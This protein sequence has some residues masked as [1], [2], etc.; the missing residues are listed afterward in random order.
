[1][2]RDPSEVVNPLNQETT[3]PIRVLLLRGH[4]QSGSRQQ[5]WLEER[6]NVNFELIVLPGAADANART[7]LM[8]ADDRERP[9]I[10]WWNDSMAPDF[11]RWRNAGLMVELTSWIDKYTVMRD[12]LNSQD[13]RSLFFAQ[14]DGR[15][16]RIPGDISEPGCETI[17]LRQDWLDTLGLAIP[18]TLAELE[19]VLYAFTHND[20][21]R[22]GQNDTYGWGAAGDD[23]R[24]FWP[25]IQGSGGGYGNHYY[26]FSRLAD[27]S[28]VYSAAHPDTRIWVERVADLYRRGL[29]T[30]NSVVNGVNFT[31]EMNRGYFGGWHRW[32]A[33]NNPTSQTT[34]LSLNPEA[35]LVPVDMVAGD[36]GR[37]QENPGFLAAWCFF[38]ITR[39]ASDPERLFALWDDMQSPGYDGPYVMKR[40]GVQGL[41]WDW[42]PDGTFNRIISATENTEM[43]FGVNIFADMFN[44]KDRWNISNTPETVALFENRGINSREAYARGVERKDVVSYPVWNRHGADLTDIRD[45]WIWSV[46]AGNESINTWDAYITRLNNAGMAEVIEELTERMA[47]QDRDMREFLS[48]RG[49]LHLIQ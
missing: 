40:H 36:N 33:T 27:G 6:Y 37:P 23:L 7:S 19:N 28:F 24:Y 22:N 4:T 15:I 43:N 25:W 38:G 8:M 20:P 30:P 46:I 12:Y 18:R 42:H 17:W 14:D 11:T 39:N 32:V 29:M 44:R 49:F 45:G 13:P 21:D 2:T 47:I 41:D 35:V 10:V 34:Y 3:M 16:Y 26:T 48:A 9:D 31:E 5:Q 1:M